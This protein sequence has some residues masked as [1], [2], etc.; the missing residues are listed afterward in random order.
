M[1]GLVLLFS[2][3]TL[4]LTIE[5]ADYPFIKSSNYNHRIR[6]YRHCILKETKVCIRD[7]YA[8]SGCS[9]NLVVTSSKTV[10]SRERAPYIR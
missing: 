2:N 7:S 10:F 1:L 9:K 5:N 8:A 6:A 3:P 4:K